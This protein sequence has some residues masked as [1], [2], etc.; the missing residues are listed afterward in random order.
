MN[1]KPKPDHPYESAMTKAGQ[2]IPIEVFQAIYKYILDKKSGN[3]QL[4]FHEGRISS[5]KIEGF[6]RF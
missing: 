5:M 4:S 1:N 2:E 6:T 3:I